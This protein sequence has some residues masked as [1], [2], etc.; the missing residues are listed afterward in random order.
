MVRVT[1]VN[2]SSNCVHRETEGV[3]QHT[4]ATV[5]H[6]LSGLYIPNSISLY[7][8]SLVPYNVESRLFKTLHSF[9]EEKA[10]SAQRYSVFFKN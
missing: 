2:R 7:V 4:A 8:R 9:F 1:I 6:L 10:V 5:A 3:C